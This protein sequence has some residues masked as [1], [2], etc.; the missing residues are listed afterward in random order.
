[1]RE[2]VSPSRS[3]ANSIQA[4]RSDRHICLS[5]PI[6]RPCLS[7]A[8]LNG[9][10]C[11]ASRILNLRVNG[12]QTPLPPEDTL[13]QYADRQG[14]RGTTVGMMTAA[15]MDTLRHCSDRVG[16][17]SLHLW[18]TCGLDN[19]RR[20]GDPADWRGESAPPAGTI[21][22]VFA[23]SLSLT[24]ATMAEL[25]MVLTEAKCAFFQDAGITSP[26]SGGIA[27]GTGTDAMVILSGSGRAERWAG[28]HTLLGERAA[29]LMMCAL[30]DCLGAAVEH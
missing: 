30:G 4:G 24:P 6:P 22:T 7:S 27:T 19:A 26:A 11:Q 28:K 29:Q 14:W 10:Y 15:P 8:P 25:L 9:G 21:N 16:E 2:S 5:W 13:R 20:A 23:T 1:M 3:E 18:L 17:E 12:E